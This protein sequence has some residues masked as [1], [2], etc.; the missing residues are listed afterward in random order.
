MRTLRN[1][2][3]AA[4]VAATLGIGLPAVAAAK[5]PKNATAQCADGTYSTAKTKQGACSKHGGV[6][7]WFADQATS[8]SVTPVT[9]HAPKNATA[10]CKD[11]TY[12]TAKTRQGACARHGGVQTWYADE[13]P[14][15]EPSAVPGTVP[16]NTAAPQNATALCKDGTYSTAKTRQGA[17]ARHG[18]VQTWYADETPA[19]EPAPV[20][21]PMPAP[22]PVPRTVASNTVTPGP[23]NATAKCKDGTLSF[24][25]THRGACS[26]HGGVAQWYKP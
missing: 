23:Q 14:A 17:C 2:M 21:V 16:G 1:L 4:C 8:S 3:T 24:S 9:K 12:S 19:P 5:P 15:P 20:T 7:T 13:T 25:K 6:Q 26:H 22:A 18:G 11:G 10:L